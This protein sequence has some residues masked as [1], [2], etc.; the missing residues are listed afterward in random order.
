MTFAVVTGAVVAGLI[1][2]AGNGRARAAETA[3]PAGNQPTAGSVEMFAGIKAGQIEVKFIPKDSTTGR[4]FIKN[5]TDKPLRVAL[6]NAAGAVPILAQMG[7]GM[8]G[9]SGGSGGGMQSMGM[10]GGGMGG[11]GMGG[12]GMGGGGGM[13]NVA[14]EKVAEIKV[15]CVCL[16]HGKAEPRP[17]A[18]YQ[19]RPIE[20]V[21]TKTG[22]RE[23]CGML[24]QIPQRVAQAAAWHLNSGMSWQQLA[25]KEIHRA[26]GTSYPYFDPAEINMAMAA[27]EHAVKTAE[28]Q[29]KTE[30]PATSPGQSVSKA[31]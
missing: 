3:K 15:P 16:D 6:P 29:P 10:G 22:V 21:T 26:D 24:G 11:G 5:K 2:A 17:T 8:G 7:G 14:P 19:L 28:A 20:N 9:M 27:A 31:P 18:T 13:F 12:G 25:E 30:Q 4:I 1:F 23:L